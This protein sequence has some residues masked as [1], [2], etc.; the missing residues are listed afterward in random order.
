M[1]FGPWTLAPGDDIK[2][3][4]AE[5]AGGIGYEKGIEVGQAYKNGDL[6]DKEKN[7]EFLKDVMCFLKLF[8]EQKPHI[9]MV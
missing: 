9:R 8:A 7:Q 3:V 6:D 5:A 1:G 2:I 4:V